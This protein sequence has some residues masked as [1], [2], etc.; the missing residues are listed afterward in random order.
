MVC[1]YIV[2][3]HNKFYQLYLIPSKPATY[4]LERGPFHVAKYVV[5]FI[6]FFFNRESFPH[7]EW[8]KVLLLVTRIILRIIYLFIFLIRFRV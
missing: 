5:F 3:T 7:V 4:V 1:S 2:S 6:F 8:E